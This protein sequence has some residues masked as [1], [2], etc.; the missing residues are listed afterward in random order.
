MR[1]LWTITKEWARERKGLVPAILAVVFLRG[2]IGLGLEGVRL[3]VVAAA[4]IGKELPVKVI[5][6]GGGQL[7]RVPIAAQPGGVLLEVNRRPVPSV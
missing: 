7:L 1:A 5:R 3:Q 4:R 2:G 6:E